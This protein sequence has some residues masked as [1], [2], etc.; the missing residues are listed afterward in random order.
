MGTSRCAV[1]LLADILANQNR[2]GEHKGR[3]PQTMMLHL[4]LVVMVLV[5]SLAVFEELTSTLVPWPVVG[6]KSTSVWELPC[7]FQRLLLFLVMFNN[8]VYVQ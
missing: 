5:Q 1:F 7:A 2:L 8:S 4:A 3:P 6:V